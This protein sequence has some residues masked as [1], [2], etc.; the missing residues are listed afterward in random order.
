MD[1]CPSFGR[2]L[3]PV[4]G[5]SPI[6]PCGHRLE[7]PAGKVSFMTTT[8]APQLCLVCQRQ[9]REALTF[10]GTAVCSDC[11]TRLTA[12]DPSDPSYDHFVERFRIFW[13]GVSEA[14]AS[15]E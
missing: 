14:A 3:S 10:C 2:Y 5:G 6:G 12:T 13:E 9:A 11:E 15:L 8:L 1:R 4:P 7:H